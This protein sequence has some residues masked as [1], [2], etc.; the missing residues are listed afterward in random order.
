MTT[1]VGS[2]ETSCAVGPD[3]NCCKSGSN[4]NKF[5]TSCYD[6]ASQTF[7]KCSQT[8]AD[9]YCQVIKKYNSFTDNF[10]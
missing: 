6:L 7:V 9:K 3:I 8:G 4:C 5:V 1:G 2:C 10:W